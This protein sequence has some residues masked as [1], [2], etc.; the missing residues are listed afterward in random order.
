MGTT[1]REILS[2]AAGFL[3]AT[4]LGTQRARASALAPDDTG[5]LPIIDTHQ[6]LW[7]LQRNSPAWLKSASGVLHH[8]YMTREYLEATK[9]LN[10]VQAVYMEVDVAPGQHVEEAT[11]I[12][13][14]C[15]EGKAPT[16]S[17]V[18]GGRPASEEFGAYLARFRQF[19]EVKGVRQVLH[20][21]ET[22]PGFC[23][24]SEFVRGIQ[25][26]GRA[27]L[28]FDLCLRPSELGD[29][30]KLVDQCPETR[31]IVDHCGNAD[32]KAFGK[33]ADGSAPSHDPEAW[34][35]GMAALAKR[36]GVMCK[37]SGVIASAPKEGQVESLVPV[38]DHCLDTFGPD[39]VMFGGDWP[40]CLQGN[41]Y[42]GWVEAL[43]TIV[44]GR[45]LADQRKL[46]H[47]N[48]AR[49]YGLTT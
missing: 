49:F 23:L 26:L 16:R 13:A 2:R 10:V 46:W 21:G 6:H 48:A 24:R 30:V 19:P 22:P 12:V 40:V 7:D 33:R 44:S 41:S 38:I 28:R 3:L 31:F 1:R 5:P 29:G 14:L 9:G 43:R 47:D 25:A 15:R 18:I 35:R 39:R 37:I 32:P 8:T 17:A 20:G 36:P 11:T 4:G 45:P 34:K 27:G 42:R